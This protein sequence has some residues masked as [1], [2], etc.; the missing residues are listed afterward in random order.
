MQSPQVFYV[1]ALSDFLIPVR[2]HTKVNQY[3]WISGQEVL[4][5]VG[6]ELWS[7]TALLQHL[8]IGNGGPT[9]RYARP[10]FLRMVTRLGVDFSKWFFYVCVNKYFLMYHCLKQLIHHYQKS[11]KLSFRCLE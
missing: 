8:Q 2:Q 1:S 11:K 5:R 9:D 7:V 3:R 6:Q 4:Q 10:G